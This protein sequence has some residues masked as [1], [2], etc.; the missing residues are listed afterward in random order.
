[1]LLSEMKRRDRGLVDALQGHVAEGTEPG[2]APMPEEP[3]TA[4]KGQPAAPGRKQTESPR[5]LDVAQLLALDV[6]PP[7][8]LVENFLPAAGACLMFG[9]AKSGKTLLAVQ[10]AL[11]V[12]GG[13]GLFDYY[14]ILE[15]GP[16]LIV[17]QDD[18]A[19]A[20]S[21]KT[22]LERS[23]VP[24][25]GIP[26]YLAPRLPFTFG[27][28][29]IAWLAEQIESRRLRLL[30]LDSY[31]AL[32]GP[33][34]AGIDIVKAEQQDMNM[35]DELAK[36]TG[37]CILVI[38]HSSKGAAGLDWNSQAAGTFAMSAAT[39][40]QI[41]I[42]RFG[43]LDTMAPERLVRIRGRHQDGAEMVLR[44]R[45]ESLDYEWIMEGGGSP[46][47]PLFLEL[48]TTF[49][50]EPF[51]PKELAHATGLSRRSANR[52]IDQLYRGDLLSRRGYGQYVVKGDIR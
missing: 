48:R 28:K 16:A 25:A 40:M 14:S 11:A 39:E 52:H 8:M 13:R 42:T 6:P 36:K 20:G 2:P 26:F 15:P 38:H 31:T 12:A 27:P 21:L 17:E 49:G 18:P 10:T 5:V 46:L 32:R 3:R 7:K 41:H 33:R 35:L 23:T 50:A 44:F 43:E 47:Y 22:I 34:H 4:P 37:C 19:G 51:G 30:I 24:V 9:S 29:L 45:R 1:M